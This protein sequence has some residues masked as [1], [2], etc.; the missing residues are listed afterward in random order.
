MILTPLSMPSTSCMHNACLSCAC[1]WCIPPQTNLFVHQC[2]ALDS[3]GPQINQLTHSCSLT[4][5]FHS[6]VGVGGITRVCYVSLWSVQT[7]Q[8][9]LATWNAHL[10]HLFLYLLFFY[11][12]CLR[13]SW[14]SAA[15]R[16][17]TGTEKKCVVLQPPFSSC[18]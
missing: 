5:T 9:P 7:L 4:S 8:P 16:Y 2:F 1:A 15:W 18:T 3:D 6:G 11:L 17:L 14:L 10:Q 12:L 13:S